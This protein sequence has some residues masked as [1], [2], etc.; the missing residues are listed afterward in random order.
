MRG[1]GL[2]ASSVEEHLGLAAWSPDGD[3]I[4]GLLKVRIEDFR[5]E[6]VASPQHSTQRGGSPP[7]ESP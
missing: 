7:S 1:E 4:G 5:V 6:E 2:S 3:G